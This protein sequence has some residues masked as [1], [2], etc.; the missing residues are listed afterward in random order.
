MLI[1]QP[2]L[3]LAL[4]EYFTSPSDDVLRRLFDT[5]NA[6]PTDG[7]PRLTRHEQILLRSSERKDLLR[8]RYEEELNRRREEEGQDDTIS[9]GRR[10]R[11]ESGSSVIHSVFDSDR[12][13]SEHRDQ[14]T[15]P[16]DTHW[17]E[18]K[19]EFRNIKVPIRIPMTTFDEDVGE[20]R[21]APFLCLMIALMMAVLDRGAGADILQR[22][23]ISWTISP[24]SPHERRQHAPGHAHPQRHA[25]A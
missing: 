24:P 25:R 8:E 17:Y 16:K 10:A 19:V 15:M 13:Q 1:G 14:R 11:S 18:T 2:L 21:H 9:M 12:K 4:E 7:M 23:A 3:L 6:I 20:V 22:R 5:C